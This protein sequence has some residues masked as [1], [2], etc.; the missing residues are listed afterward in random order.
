MVV[1]VAVAVDSCGCCGC[2]GGCS[3]NDPVAVLGNTIDCVGRCFFFA[4]FLVSHD[5]YDSNSIFC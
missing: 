5:G 3:C 1:A 4:S 2:C